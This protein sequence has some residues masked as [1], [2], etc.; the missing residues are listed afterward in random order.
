MYT[1]ILGLHR[2]EPC[3]VKYCRTCFQSIAKSL[4]LCLAYISLE[5]RI[6][7]VLLRRGVTEAFLKA[8]PLQKRI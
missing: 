4:F 2:F 7:L 1:E 8:G 3:Q 6:A 5:Y